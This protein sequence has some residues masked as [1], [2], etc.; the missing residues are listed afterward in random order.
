M[1]PLNPRWHRLSL[2]HALPLEKHARQTQLHLPL[3]LLN[4]HRH[5]EQP[6]PLPYALLP[7]RPTAAHR[8]FRRRPVHDLEVVSYDGAFCE[9]RGENSGARPEVR[10]SRGIAVFA[11]EVAA[12]EVVC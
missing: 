11:R 3:L 12:L 10:L 9:I 2:R 7:W 5:L 1:Q 4:T 8:H 6:V